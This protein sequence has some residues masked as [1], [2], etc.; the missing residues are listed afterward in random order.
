MSRSKGDRTTTQ[1]TGTT[2]ST[3]ATNVDPA[4]QAYV[5]QMRARASGAANMMDREGSFFAGPNA[6]FMQGLG[7]LNQ[8]LSGLGPDLSRYMTN[9]GL[10]GPNLPGTGTD[11]SGMRQALPED[12]GQLNWS[13]GRMDVNRFSDFMNPYEQAVIDSMY[14]T[15]DRQR[16]GAL[17]AAAQ[18]ATA[19]GAFGGSRG[20]ILQAQGLRD[21]NQDEAARIA[22]LR[23]QGYQ[24]AQGL[25]ANEWQTL[26]NLGLQAAIANQQGGL[27]AAGLQLQGDLGFAGMQLQQD[28][29]GANQELQRLGLGVQ[30]GLGFAG[31]QQQQDFQR[32]GMQQAQAQQQMAAGEYLRGLEERKL[33]EDVWRQQMGLGFLQSSIGPYG[34]TST[35]QGTSNQTQTQYTQP[36]WGSM[37]SQGI[38]LASSLYGSGLF[39]NL[40]GGGGGAPGRPGFVPGLQPGGGPGV[41]G[42]PPQF[43][44]PTS[45]INPQSAQVPVQFGGNPGLFGMSPSYAR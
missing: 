17:T 23:Q 26:Q 19:A 33:Q 42:G 28:Q 44:M 8:D 5:E 9:L 29:F 10:G 25:A 12:L 22:A 24:Q 38:G 6:Q 34:T 4:T 37:L 36:G 16:Q 40:F 35:Q 15:G 31:L 41:F 27:A 30:Q 1:T 45:F 3:A 32:A 20:E 13:G 14:A 7:N 21:V 11:L 18:Q 2:S 43:A 39:G